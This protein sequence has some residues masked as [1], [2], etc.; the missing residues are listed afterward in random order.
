MASCAPPPPPLRLVH[1][2][3]T[4]QASCARRRRRRPNRL[5]ATPTTLPHPTKRDTLFGKPPL[6]PPDDHRVTVAYTARRPITHIDAQPPHH[7][8]NDASP[9]PPRECECCGKGGNGVHA[10]Y[11]ILYKSRFSHD[12]ETGPSSTESARLRNVTT[13]TMRMIMI[14]NNKRKIDY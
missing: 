2:R 1:A 13:A 9:T 5:H 12:R 11:I 14:N 6:P 4:A 8:F 7:L 3:G 10:L